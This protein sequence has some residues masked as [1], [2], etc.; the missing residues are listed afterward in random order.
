[1]RNV[2]TSQG[3]YLGQEIKDLITGQQ[4]IIKVFGLS[5]MG[6]WH[7]GMCP[8]ELDGEGRQKPTICHSEECFKP[9]GASD[10]AEPEFEDEELPML[11]MV[12][13]KIGDQIGQ[14][15]HIDYHVTGCIRYHVTT[16]Q[17]TQ[18]GEVVL[19]YCD[20]DE[21]EL[22]EPKVETS[23]PPDPGKRPRSPGQ[24]T[25]GISRPNWR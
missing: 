21:I 6:A 17:I 15:R 2:R 7:I 9:V 23:N 13:R 11:A 1:M 16:G 4:G 25:T 14:I 20:P 10:I 3:F 5:A 12:R 8:R 24:E 22:I 19:L 18:N